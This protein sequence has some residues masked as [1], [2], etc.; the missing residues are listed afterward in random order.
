MSSLRRIHMFRV[1]SFLIIF[2]LLVACLVENFVVHTV[3]FPHFGTSGEWKATLI[4]V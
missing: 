2:S 4:L 1:F 3:L